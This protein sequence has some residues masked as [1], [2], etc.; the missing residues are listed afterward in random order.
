MEKRVAFRSRWLPYVLVAPQ[1][2]LDESESALAG[3]VQGWLAGTDTLLKDRAK[4]A[5]TLA[6]FEG[7]PEALS[8]LHLLADSEPSRL[9]ENTALL[10]L[11]GRGAVSIESL[12]DWQFRARRAAHLGRV[13]LDTSLVDGRVVAR[14]VRQNPKLLQAAEPPKRRGGAG[15]AGEPLLERTFPKEDEE[16]LVGTIGLLTA[17]F[18]RYDVR[19][20]LPGRAAKARGELL[21]RAA[22]RYDLDRARLL[23]SNGPVKNG[24]AASL[25]V[26]RAP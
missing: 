20:T 8:L 25:Q 1:P 17:V 5:R 23:V 22:L 7:A 3:F 19:L 13:A 18:P 6:G 21:D 4:A 24:A 2:L 10:G 11:S 15:T 12:A 26:L 16:A 14:V 9:H